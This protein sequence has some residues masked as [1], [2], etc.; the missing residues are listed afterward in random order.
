MKTLFLMRHAKSSW[1]NPGW[2]DFERP[3]NKRGLEAA[4][5]MGQYMKRNKIKPDVVIS[6]PA[7][8]AKETAELVIE[9]AE[10]EVDLRFDERIYE[11]TVPDLMKVVSEIKDEISVVLLVGHNPGFEELLSRLTGKTERMP[12]AALANINLDINNWSDVQDLCGKLEWLVKP[13]EL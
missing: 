6:S 10:F 8:R 9:A 12:T 2:R 3:L 7:V 11:A 5:T 1:D 4:P 13:K